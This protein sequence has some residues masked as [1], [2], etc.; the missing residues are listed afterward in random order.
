MNYE[1]L[2]DIIRMEQKKAV[3]V[4]KVAHGYDPNAPHAK[5]TEK[6]SVDGIDQIFNLILGVV[7]DMAE[8]DFLKAEYEAEFE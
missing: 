5:L 1:A 3:A 6:A 7:A 8:L 2:R 4:V